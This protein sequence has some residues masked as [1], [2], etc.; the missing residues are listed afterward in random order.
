LKQPFEFISKKWVKTVKDNEISF[1]RAVEQ[2]R[3]NELALLRSLE[4][5]EVLS[6]EADKVKNA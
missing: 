2:L 1:N 6:R 4:T 3:D 5:I